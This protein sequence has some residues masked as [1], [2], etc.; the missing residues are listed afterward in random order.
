MNLAPR[1]LQAH[2][3]Q[4]LL[5]VP[6]QYLVSRVVHQSD[7]SN[8]TLD[9]PGTELMTSHEMEDTSSTHLSKSDVTGLE[10]RVMEKLDNRNNRLTDVESKLAVLQ[11]QIAD[12]TVH[13]ANEHWRVFLTGIT[14]LTQKYEFDMPFANLDSFLEF[15]E[16]LK[17]E[18]F[19]EGKT[20]LMITHPESVAPMTNCYKLFHF[21]SIKDVLA[22]YAPVQKSGTRIIFKKTQFYKCLFD[23][24]ISLYSESKFDFSDEILLGFVDSVIKNNG[25]WGKGRAMR[26][27]SKSGS[28]VTGD[29]PPAKRQGLN[30]DSQ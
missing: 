18:I 26:I 20:Y 2:S 17:G 19:D 3:P 4:Q 21:F 16:K 10:T 9:V 29:D 6:C 7:A 22:N 8:V 5:Q 24:F 12:L 25:D 15:D 27:K 23:A 13:L 1:H 11:K 30:E 28:V 14:T